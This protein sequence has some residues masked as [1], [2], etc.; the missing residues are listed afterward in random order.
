MHLQFK[1]CMWHRPEGKLNTELPLR[2]TCST[3]A[4]I[5]WELWLNGA[6]MPPV[7]NPFDDSLYNACGA[8]AAAEHEH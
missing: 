4:E 6:G 8:L 1:V 2:P 7:E 5:D 3:Q